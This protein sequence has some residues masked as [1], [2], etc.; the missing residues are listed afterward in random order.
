MGIHVSSW[1]WL[2][3]RK[4]NE[5]FKRETKRLGIG[6]YIMIM[7]WYDLL[8]LEMDNVIFSI[9]SKLF[10]LLWKPF[11]KWILLDLCCLTRLVMSW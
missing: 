9:F 10:S 7:L 6:K 3:R 2:R 11:Q 5:A 8:Q 1:K 4:A